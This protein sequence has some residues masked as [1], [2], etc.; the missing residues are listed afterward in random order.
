MNDYE[1]LI[2]CRKCGDLLNK[3]NFRSTREKICHDCMGF[4]KQ[5]CK[6]CLELKFKSDF[7]YG[8]TECKKCSGE[9]QDLYRKPKPR[10]CKKCGKEKLP[11]DFRR[12]GR[13]CT[14]CKLSAAKT[15]KI[16]F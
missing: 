4:E 15:K 16:K 3:T 14:S 5:R 6:L 8:R 10:K 13:I 7:Y 9:I 12:G 11:K 1:G 2:K